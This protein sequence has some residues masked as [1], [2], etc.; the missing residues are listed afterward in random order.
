M[1]NQVRIIAGQWRGRKLV[2]PDITGLR[3]TPNRIRETLFNWLQQDVVNSRCLDLYA[4]SGALGFEAVSRQARSALLVECDKQAFTAIGHNIE[5]FN[6]SDKIVVRLTDVSGFIK[7]PSQVFDLVFLDPPFGQGLVKFSCQW[8]ESYG[9]L[10]ANAKIY[11]EMDDQEIPPKVPANWRL[12]RQNSAGSV[13]YY[14]FE[15][16]NNN[17]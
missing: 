14:L 9:W 5:R 13:A 3:P 11:L 10:A 15:R 16:K 2:F 17:H 8:L 4:G 12:L 7:G 6:A 1:K